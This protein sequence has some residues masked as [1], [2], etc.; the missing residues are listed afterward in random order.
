MKTSFSRIFFPTAIL[1]LCAMLLVGISFQFLVKDYMQDKTVEQLRQNA[2]TVSQLAGAYYTSGSVT[3]QD[4]YMNLEVFSKTSGSDAIICNASGRLLLCSD[5]LMGCSHIGMQLDSTYLERVMRTGYAASTGRIEGL[6]PDARYV[7]SMPFYDSRGAAVGVVLVSATMSDTLLVLHRM[8]ELYLG[9]AVAVVL[10]AVLLVNLLAR[11]VSR[12]LKAMAAT[13][14]DFGHGKLDARAQVSRSSP[15]EVQEL[16]L[17]FNNMAESLQKSEYQRQEFVSNVSHELKTPMTTIGGYIDGML[18]GTIPPQQQRKYMQIVSGE[19]KRLSRLVRSMLDIS[20]LQNEGGVTEAQKTRF[21]MCEC[22]GR[23]L[24][25][26]EQ[27]I[28]TKQLQVNVAFPEHPA[29]TRADEDAITQVLYNLTDN[30]VKFCRPEGELGLQIRLGDSKLY[31]SVSNDGDTIPPQELPRVFDRFHKLDKSRTAGSEGWGLGL[32]IVKTIIGAHG[33]DI[34]V[35]SR[36]GR[37]E[38]TFCLPLVN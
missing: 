9:V 38:F 2:D 23:V 37:T 28:L 5:S 17:A 8:T 1:L 6:Y 12:P 19:T 24:I 31:V 11:N 34:S 32:Y 16:A 29:Y 21:D 36:D 14:T 7:V 35:S 18:D 15:V 22:A 4:F 33:E 10:V 27:K 20:R 30:A 3:G 13:A 26:F 25:A